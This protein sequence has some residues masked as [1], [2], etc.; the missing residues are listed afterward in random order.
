MIPA[1]E[2]CGLIKTYPGGARV[3]NGLSFN[4]GTG[5]VFG[6]V[7]ENGAGKSTLIK[8]LATLLTPSAGQVRILGLDTRKY[9]ARIKRRLGVATQDS[10]LDVRLS[11][12][13]NLRFHGRYFGLDSG[14]IDHA[15]DYWLERLGLTDKAA[16]RVYRLSGGTRRRLMLAKAFLTDPD[17]V[18]LD[19]PTAGL[20]PEARLQVWEAVRVFRRQNKTVLLSTHHYEEARSLCDRLL[21][22]REG[23]GECLNTL[24][25]PAA[26]FSEGAVSLS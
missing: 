10:H 3:L 13:Q 19:E 16:E 15:A 22:L 25:E 21:L 24:A 8:I 17:L 26:P 6:L 20:D 14:K 5:E 2:V 7:G 1:I 23:R 12:R 4:V 18:I 9:P 11:V